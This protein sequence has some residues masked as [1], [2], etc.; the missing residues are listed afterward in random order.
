MKLVFQ[1][2]QQEDAYFLL[3]LPC[4]SLAFLILLLSSALPA[5]GQLCGVDH[6]QDLYCLLP[7]T[8]HLP[9][10]AFNAF[11][12]PFGTELSELPTARPAGLVLTFEHG[13][14]VPSNESLG[15]IFTERAEGIGRH[16]VF[17][18]FTYQN[19]DFGSIDGLNLKQIPIVL[20]Y[21]PTQITTA[22]QMRLDIRVGQYTFVAA[23]GLTNRV[24]VSVAIPLERVSFT[25]TVSGTEYSLGGVSAAFGEH[26]PGRSSGI[27]DVI[28]GVKGLV[29]EHEGTSFTAGT[30]VRLPTGDE[31]NFL[32]SGTIGVRPYLALSRRGR[33]S[34]HLNVGYQWNGDSILNASDTGAKQQLPTDFF[35]AFGANI[36]A[37]KRLTVTADLLGRHFFDAPRFTAATQVAIVGIGTAPSIA[38]N[39]GSYTTS[40]LSLGFKTQTFGHLLLTGNVTLKLND[41]GLRAR[42]IPLVGASYSF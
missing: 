10:Y 7:S 25:S 33:L 30:D 26:V 39:T 13:I 22:T 23:A 16:R 11:F 31:L 41:D 19:F 18:G 38:P 4:R 2:P 17:L 27:A 20:Y 15:A 6:T 1:H 34:P 35:Y 5:L 8:F 28:L 12:T 32:G 36:E 21:P 37:A 24:D 9:A 40:D 14:L 3:K 42:A 29:F